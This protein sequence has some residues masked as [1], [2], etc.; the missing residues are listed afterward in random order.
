MRLKEKLTQWRADKAFGFI[1]PNGGGSDV[2]IHKTAFENKK[3]YHKLM[4]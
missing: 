3:E 4:T 2:F 1:S